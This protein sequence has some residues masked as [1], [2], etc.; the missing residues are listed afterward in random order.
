MIV[1]HQVLQSAGQQQCPVEQQATAGAAAAP[2][3]SAGA[4]S[5]FVS[6]PGEQKKYVSPSKF[7]EPIAVAGSMVIPHTGSVTA[8]IVEEVMGFS[9]QRG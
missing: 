2:T 4:A 1:F 7:E 3:Y 9:F 8:A 6:H 5:N